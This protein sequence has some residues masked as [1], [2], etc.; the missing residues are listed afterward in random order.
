[1][2]IPGKPFTEDKASWSIWNKL[3]AKIK[4]IRLNLYYLWRI[5]L[6]AR[7]KRPDILLFRFQQGHGFFLPIMIL[8]YIYPVVLEINAI[9]TIEDPS[10]ASWISNLFDKWSLLRARKC[11]VVSQVIKEHIIG[12]GLADGEKVTVIEN[13]VDV[14]LF[15]N[16]CTPD[17][18]KRRLGF[19]N[20]FVA[21]F[22]GSFQPWHGVDNIVKLAES[23][24]L[25]IPDILFLIVGDGRDRT[26]Y[27][28]MV[29]IKGLEKSVVFTGLISHDRVRE[30][31]AAMDVALAP[32]RSDS[33][34]GSGGFHGSPLKI[35][36]YMAMKKAVI[37]A[38]IGQ[39]K[40][41]IVDGESGMLIHSEDVLSLKNA[42][43][44]LN[45]DKTYRE[46][47][48]MNA[49]QRVE[50]YYTWKVNAEKVLEVCYEAMG[51]FKR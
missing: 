42:L 9:R 32:H 50:K 33:F 1:M 43:V 11:F 31:L 13:G 41:V 14:D 3:M 4:W 15:R 17:E 24:K 39:I 45:N 2:G 25:E 47:L 26:V 20:R 34:I 51:H 23:L 10:A 16:H 49:R 38:P 35:F 7:K 30:Y 19:E 40:E 18:A 27:E 46:L 28:E 12:R 21:G 29:K 48:G 44:K 36:E 22:V 8:S 5:F 37:A 6:M